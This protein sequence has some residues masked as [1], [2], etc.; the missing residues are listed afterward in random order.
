MNELRITLLGAFQVTLDGQA[1]TAFGTDKTRALLAYLVMEAYRPHRREHLAALLWSD[2]PE[3]KALHSL[4]QSVSTLRK[5][6]HAG[7]PRLPYLDI[8]RESIRFN[9]R[10]AYRLD[11]AV[12]RDALKEGLPRDGYGQRRARLDIRRL[13]R[14]LALYRGNFLDQ[15]LLRGSP[16]FDEWA[17]VQRE[18]LARQFVEGV[19]RLVAYHE[20]RG[21]FGQAR[22][23][24]ERLAA[25]LPWDEGAQRTILK[26]LA[27]RARWHAAEMQFS[28]LE[29]NLRRELG[30]SA[31]PQTL[32]LMEE[33]RA[34]AARDVPLPPSRPPARSNLPPPLADFVG[35]DAELD[36][37]STLLSNPHT[38]LITLTGPGGVGKSRLA[39]RAAREQRG[40]FAEGVFFVPLAPVHAAEQLPLALAESLGF[41]FYSSQPPLGLLCD[42][43]RGKEMLLVLDNFEHLLLEGGAAP[44]LRILEEAPD[45]VVLATSRQPLG[46]RVE[47]VLEVGGLEY[48]PEGSGNTPESAVQLFER[49]ARRG[50]P[51]FSLPPQRAA[52]RRICRLVEGLPL[53]I[54]LSAVW[55]RHYSPA[56]IARQIEKDLDFLATSMPDFPARH[57]SLRTVFEHSWQLLDA[58]ERDVFCKLSVFQGGFLPEAARRVA[59]AER[60]HL[61]ALRDKS[62]LH[63]AGSGRLDMHVLLRQ[64]AAEKLGVSPAEARAAREAHSAFFA[65]YLQE[66]ESALQGRTPGEALQAV[67]LEIENI[68]AAWQWA[69]EEGALSHLRRAAGALGRFYDMRS[70]FAEGRDAFAQAAERLR[71]LPAPDERA[72][73]ILGQ[74]TAQLAWFEVQMGAYQEAVEHLEV[75]RSRLPEACSRER[76]A[77]LNVLGSARYELGEFERATRCFKEAIE[78]ASTCDAWLALAFAN[79]YLGSIARTRGEFSRAET[80]F[81]RSLDFYQRLEDQWGIAR[82]FNNLGSMA[83][84]AGD[85]SGAK[86]AFERSL[87]IRRA[88]GDQAGVAGCLHNLSV[89][90]FIAE[91][92]PAARQLRRE[93][94]GICREI[95]FIW[96]IASTLKHLGDVEKAEGD[97]VQARAHYVESLAISER[98][99]DR[100]ST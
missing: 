74:V 49:I 63:P 4:R 12:F 87:A 75:V 39:L 42:H 52:V 50:A 23:A 2:Q 56:E 20:K 86:K 48:A 60:A 54:E 8:R 68:R 81:T 71:A 38:R 25:H 91:D 67:A 95:G 78:V 73:C 51:T 40:I 15:M 80:F 92:Y 76:A 96:G 27:H 34:C 57:R 79:N 97:W 14:A 22:E 83:G 90:A 47:R 62:L 64:F 18:M 98:R 100:R 46:L 53:G 58:A 16:L 72:L 93:C 32:S 28:A 61:A 21:E 45:V 37:L 94:L 85:Y 19:G 6:L 3:K 55:V 89:L 82:V 69:I 24:A 31:S 11:V 36:E 26:M 5:L 59:G 35:R 65:A 99:G 43:L 41:A 30:V 70:W 84:V 13:R 1:L 77:L 17:I 44:V 9:P 10:S 29:R 33:I 66:Q 88:L 7:N